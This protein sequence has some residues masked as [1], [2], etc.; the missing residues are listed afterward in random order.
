MQTQQSAK[1][2]RFHLDKVT[3]RAGM[4][5]EVVVNASGAIPEGAIIGA[6]GGTLGVRPHSSLFNQV[7][8]ERRYPYAL[9]FYLSDYV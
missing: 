1:E 2:E 5:G 7:R 8:P 4:K 3:L 9:F 6:I